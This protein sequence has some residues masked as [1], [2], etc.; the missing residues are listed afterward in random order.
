VLKHAYKTPFPACNV[1]R[2]NE[3]VATDTVYAYVPAID[4]G[5]TRA[6]IFVGRDSLVTDIVGMSTDKQFVN[7]LEDNIRYRGAMDKLISDRAQL[8]ISNRAKDL[9]R[10]MADKFR[11]ESG[12]P[13]LKRC[14]EGR[15][16]MKPHNKYSVARIARIYLRSRVR[17]FTTEEL[18]PIATPEPRGRRSIF[19]TR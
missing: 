11:T 4:C 12:L 6:Q 14:A 13:R 8:E 2:W 5:H 7:T 1:R 9:L 17:G 15:D 16:P 18:I 3:A 19:P 10:A